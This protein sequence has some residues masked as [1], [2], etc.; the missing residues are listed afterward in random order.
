N[1]SMAK[2]PAPMLSVAGSG[3]FFERRLTMILHDHVPRKLS[4]AGLVGVCLLLLFALP[5][6]SAAVATSSNRDVST[7][8]A[9]PASVDLAMN[10]DDD[11]DDDD[12]KERKRDKDDD[13]A[14]DDDDDSDDN[15]ADDEDDDAD[16]DDDRS[17]AKA[18]AKSK[19]SDLD[20][21][22]DLSRIQKEIEEKL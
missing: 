13:D 10:L 7:I 15:D 20:I 2:P 5:S 11:D 17:Q 9:A 3:R 8:E 19:K 1:L 4:R 14:D 18:K 16:D 21:E 22:V 12:D 6:W